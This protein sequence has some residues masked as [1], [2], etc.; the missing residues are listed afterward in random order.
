MQI[1]L[2]FRTSKEYIKK[3][4]LKQYA[5]FRSLK[6]YYQVLIILL[7]LAV[8]WM[9]SGCI[10]KNKHKS[11]TLQGAS[12]AAVYQTQFSQSQLHDEYLKFPAVTRAGKVVEIRAQTSGKVQKIVAKEGEVLNKGD[13]IL[14]LEQREKND[15]VKKTIAALKKAKV[16]YEA[17]K[18]LDAKGYSSKVRLENVKFIYESAISDYKKAVLDLEDSIIKAPFTGVLDTISVEEGQYIDDS[19]DQAAVATM[20]DNSDLYVSAYIAEK[21]INNLVEDNVVEVHY[22]GKVFPGR[23]TTVSRIA[24]PLTRTFY[25]EAE[26]KDGKECG[27]ASGVSVNLDISLRKLKA[28]ELPLSA[29]ILDDSG[30]FRVKYLEDKIVKSS[31]VEVIDE[32]DGHIWVANLPD[33]AEI[34]VLGGQNLMDGANVSE[35]NSNPN[36]VKK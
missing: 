13:I 1:K 9:M 11:F 30:E 23:V 3:Q 10:I 8:L 34:V 25:V 16:S 26:V 21:Y 18:A 4:S 6:L 2:L 22:E 36:E 35:L 32:E 28:H 24:D 5:K 15:N 7:I 27:L 19:G 33:N 31:K 12:P 17:E 20:L 29:L 14:E